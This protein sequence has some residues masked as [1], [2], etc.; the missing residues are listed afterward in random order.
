MYS[1]ITLDGLAAFHCDQHLLPVP[2]LPPLTRAL[3]RDF[4]V[5]DE[6]PTSSR[7]KAG[8]CSDLCRPNEIHPA[9]SPAREKSP[10]DA[11]R[12]AWIRP[13]WS[14]RAVIQ[15]NENQNRMG[16]IQTGESQQAENHPRENQTD[17]KTQFGGGVIY[18]KLAKHLG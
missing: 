1:G 15:S 2:N 5:P 13:A 12:P 14:R 8:V 10:K 6:F 18:P 16:E 17:V 3:I 7:I 4:A 9:V 11:C